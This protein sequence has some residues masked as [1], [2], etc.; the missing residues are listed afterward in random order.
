MSDKKKPS[1]QYR[2]KSAGERISITAALVAHGFT[3]VGEDGTYDEKKY[4][5][6]NTTLKTFGY[7]EKKNSEHRDITISMILNNEYRVKG[8]I[9]NINLNHRIAGYYPVVSK[10][11][12][13]FGCQTVTFDQL[14]TI[15]DKVAQM[16]TILAAGEYEEL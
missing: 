13:L 11:G 15:N 8:E 4:V 14:K 3:R 6:I 1:L 16:K 2:T 12:V 10:D 5:V 9:K 7:I